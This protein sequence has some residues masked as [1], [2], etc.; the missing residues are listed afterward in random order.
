MVDRL[1]NNLTGQAKQPY[2]TT[3]N[4]FY[5]GGWEAVA[6]LGRIHKD[7]GDRWLIKLPGNVRI[8]CDKQHRSFYSRQHC[9]WTLS[10]I[11]AELEIGTF[12]ADF[13]AKSKKSLQSFDVYAEHWLQQCERK[14]TLG[15]LSKV[16]FRHLR[17]CV[18]NLF[19]PFFGQLNILDI[20]GKHVN[21]FWLSLEKAPK[22]IYNIMAALHRLF[23]DAHRDEVIQKVPNFP[24]ELRPSDLPEPNW[25]WASEEVQEQ[26]F[27][28][29]DPEDLYFILFQASHGTRT[30]ET[31]PTSTCSK[32]AKPVFGGY[33]NKKSRDI[34][35]RVS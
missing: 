13:Y 15:K 18:R 1:K 2:P 8:F 27:E 35:M 16:H 14:V 9:E 25:Q 19:N 7:T 34:R 23:N 6:K 12:D 21:E 24:P 10:Q 26:I 5:A 20:K 28:H 11:T 17:H 31:S 33:G 3:Q 22:T 29:L 4:K 30:G 32:C